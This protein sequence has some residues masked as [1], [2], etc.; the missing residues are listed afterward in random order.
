MCS[1][2]EACL[3][4][5]AVGV[6]H[7]LA[8]AVL[9]VNLTSTFQPILLF[10][11]GNSYEDCV[12]GAPAD[13][14]VYYRQGGQASASATPADGAG[15]VTLTTAVSPAMQVSARGVGD[16]GGD[17]FGGSRKAVESVGGILTV[18]IRP[19]PSTA[20]ASWTSDSSRGEGE[21]KRR[22]LCN[23]LIMF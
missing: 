13:I 9:F 6:H 8:S 7:V 14:V 4:G 21:D 12:G 2:F 16:E 10:L 20:P 3:L 19:H 18:I 1:L 15:N 11:F 23:V 5:L 17:G 22:V